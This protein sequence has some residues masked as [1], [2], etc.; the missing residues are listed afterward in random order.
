MVEGPERLPHCLQRYCREG[1]MPQDH[2]CPY[3]HNESGCDVGEDYISPH[4]V[5][6][7]VE[8]C[9]GH[10]PECITYR[11][12]TEHG[13]DA[14][15]KSATIDH[16]ASSQHEVSLTPLTRSIIAMFGLALGLCLG[17]PH[18]IASSFATVSLMAGGLV[19]MV[20][21]LHDWRHDKPFAATINC[22]Y[23]LFGVSLI[24]LVTLPQAGI[25]ATPDPWGTTS[26]L[27]MWGLFSIAI[28]LTAFEYDR[29]LGSVF[30]LLTAAILTLSVA[31]AIGSDSLARSA[32][33][34]FVAS[35][36]VGL[37]PMLL[38]RRSE[39]ALATSRHPDTL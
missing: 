14:I 7:I 16:P 9:N 34:L 11:M 12:I 3:F 33:V 25:S 19:L 10:Y 28:Y 31:T 1:H 2:V 15:K 17:A 30:G 39:H 6:T 20:H 13:M 37:L 26:Y 24:P 38:Q 36:L 8:F 29:W 23:G 4:D 18:G 21:G 35:S 32:G 27:A 5:E 22:A